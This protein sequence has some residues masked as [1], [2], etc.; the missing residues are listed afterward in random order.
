[1]AREALNL[2]ALAPAAAAALHAKSLAAAS[3][4]LWCSLLLLAAA[5][6]ASRLGTRRHCNRQSGDASGKK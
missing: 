3:A 5:V 4:P 6:P 2:E 1:M